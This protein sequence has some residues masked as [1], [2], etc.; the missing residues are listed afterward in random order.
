MLE[1]WRQRDGAMRP[2]WRAVPLAGRQELPVDGACT[3]APAPVGAGVK[4]RLLDLF[5]GAGGAG[6][7]YHRAG[8]DVTGVDIKPMPRYPFTFNQADALEYV[9][10]HGHEFDVIHASPPCQAYSRM[11]RITKR[12][13]PDLIASTRRA[14]N[15]VGL[16]YVIEN[17]EGA[18]LANYLTLCG[19]MFGLPLR[20]HRWFE[21]SPASYPLMTP[22]SCQNGVATGRLIGQR[23]RGPKP[24]NRRVPPVFT[25]SE[26]R[27]A[28]GVEWMTIQECQEAIPPAYTSFIGRLLLNSD[29]I[30]SS[31]SFSSDCMTSGEIS[32]SRKLK[33][34][35]AAVS[36]RK[37][38]GSAGG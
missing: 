8:F 13:Y 16:P 20:R 25:E 30:A 32:R 9:T 21:M 24:A 37:R 17:V 38:H 15:S 14:L 11:R 29:R 3:A 12:E 5:C 33:A 26:K 7:G 4:P 28:I 6:M 23:L 31:V 19:T 36:Q 1:L 22:C 35:D 10:E 18:P 34:T 27:A 2:V